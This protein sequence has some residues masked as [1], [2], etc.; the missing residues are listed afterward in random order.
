MQESEKRDWE[1]K[2]KTIIVVM[3]RSQEGITDRWDEAHNTE[4]IILGIE[5]KYLTVLKRKKNI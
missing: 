1:R 4:N 2:S 3:E 5:K